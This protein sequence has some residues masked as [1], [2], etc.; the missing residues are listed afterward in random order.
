VSLL[1][2]CDGIRSSS[3][4]CKRTTRTDDPTW[5]TLTPPQVRSQMA[6]GADKHFCSIECI[7]GWSYCAMSGDNCK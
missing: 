5:Y 4:H 1:Q 7:H 6:S 2:E 3:G